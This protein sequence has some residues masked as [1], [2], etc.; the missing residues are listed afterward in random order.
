MA[1]GVGYPH[2]IK[3]QGIYAYVTLMSHVEESEAL[4]TEL[5]DLVRKVA[6]IAPFAILFGVP[7][8]CQFDLGLF[9]AGCGE[10]NESKTALFAVITFEFDESE[11]LAVKVQGFVDVGDAHH[12]M[13]VFHRLAPLLS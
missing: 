2:E 11:L 3:G 7:V 5:V 9:V 6:E 4:R 12:G 1:A 8:V 10:K 13:E